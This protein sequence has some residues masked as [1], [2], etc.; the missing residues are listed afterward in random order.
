MRAAISRCYSPSDELRATREG[1]RTGEGRSY[2]SAVRA[3]WT[4]VRILILLACAYVFLASPVFASSP[5]GTTIVTSGVIIDAVALVVAVVA[6]WS[7]WRG[8][9]ALG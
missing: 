9:R 8:R 4:L 6:G 7:L 3:L 2:A 1:A 5:S